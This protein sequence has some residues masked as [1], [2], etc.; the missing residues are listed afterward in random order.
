[1]LTKQ[2]ALK[3]IAKKIAE[4][5]ELMTEAT[6]L[7]EKHEIQYKSEYGEIFYDEENEEESEE[8]YGMRR[9]LIKWNSSSC[10]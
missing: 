2:E 3:Q 10:Y 9:S 5:T 6:D 1:M 4:A 8:L 7:A